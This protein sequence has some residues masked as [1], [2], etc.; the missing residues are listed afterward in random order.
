MDKSTS[1]QLISLTKRLP[2][3]SHFIWK[4]IKKHFCFELTEVE[5]SH[6]L[7]NRFITVLVPDW[8]NP[9]QGKYLFL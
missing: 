2:G 3:G 9:K 1:V 5:R 6:S 4:I 7:A 8:D